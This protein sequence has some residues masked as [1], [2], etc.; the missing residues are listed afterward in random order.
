[1]H[2]VSIGILVEHQEVAAYILG[3]GLLISFNQDSMN[4]V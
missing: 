4:A 2:G 1:M 3:W